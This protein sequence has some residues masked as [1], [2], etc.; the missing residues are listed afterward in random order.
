MLSV[1]VIRKG[2]MERLK[3]IGKRIIRKAVVLWLLDRR[4]HVMSKEVILLIPIANDN[5]WFDATKNLHCSDCACSF[6]GGYCEECIWALS[7]QTRSDG[8]TLFPRDDV[9]T[10][11]T[12][13]LMFSDMLWFSACQTSGHCTMQS[14]PP[15][16]LETQGKNIQKLN[17]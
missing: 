14:I 16:G 6:V 17:I 9:T 8:Y 2:I 15:M 7:I 4:A 12:Q 1:N 5:I 10:V 3:D 11:C 13:Y